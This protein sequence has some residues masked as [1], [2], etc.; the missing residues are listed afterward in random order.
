M[1][2]KP[3]ILEPTS[4]WR[5]EVVT[6]NRFVNRHHG[7]GMGYR[8]SY[9]EVDTR[10]MSLIEIDL[11]K[12]QLVTMLVGAEAS[13]SKRENFRRLK[14]SGHILLDAD[15]IDTLLG[16]NE[17]RIPESWTKERNKYGVCLPVFFPGTPLISSEDEDEDEDEL[18]FPSMRYNGR[19]WDDDFFPHKIVD[20]FDRYAIL[21]VS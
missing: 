4:L 17:Y 20:N 21:P 15:I 2:D 9:D 16:K 19:R 5:K 12:V 3:T 8:I 13:I 6:I 18:D 1:K 10:S 7:V 11:T 14:K